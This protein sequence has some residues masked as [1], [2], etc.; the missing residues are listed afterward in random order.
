MKEEGNPDEVVDDP[1]H[2]DGVGAEFIKQENKKLLHSIAWETGECILAANG[3]DLTELMCTR[4]LSKSGLTSS[5]GKRV[6]LRVA[7]NLSVVEHTAVGFSSVLDDITPLQ[8]EEEISI[9]QESICLLRIRTN[10]SKYN[11]FI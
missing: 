3:A 11:L 1:M 9:D 5:M 4:P 2:M 7:P 6:L 10:N 8:S